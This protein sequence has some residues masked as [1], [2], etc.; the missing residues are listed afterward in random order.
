[1]HQL[2]R[3]YFVG[4]SVKIVV[5]M[6]QPNVFCLSAPPC[7]GVSLLM[8]GRESCVGPTPKK[9]VRIPNALQA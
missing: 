2:L 6:Y 4:M 9:P 5:I 3:I 8:I 1:M 7:C